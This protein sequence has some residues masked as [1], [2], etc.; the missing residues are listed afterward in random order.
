MTR[1][2]PT[3]Y[4][5]RHNVIEAKRL[6]QR[7]GTFINAVIDRTNSLADMRDLAKAQSALLEQTHHLD[8]L[9]RIARNQHKI[10][11]PARTESAT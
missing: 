7:T 5:A 9:D 3:G 6:N 4:N 10:A 1:P 11:D 2:K 8:E